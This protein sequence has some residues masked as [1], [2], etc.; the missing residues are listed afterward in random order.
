ML[1]WCYINLR[2]LLVVFVILNF[3]KFSNKFKTST[4]FYCEKYNP[5]TTTRRGWEAVNP[6]IGIITTKLK[7]EQVI[8][9]I[10]EA[11]A[12]DPLNLQSFQQYVINMK[13]MNNFKMLLGL[14]D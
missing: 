12:V 9:A 10:A 4:T 1:V 7:K 11:V 14:Q 6:S 8:L 3:Y 2:R 13:H 5:R